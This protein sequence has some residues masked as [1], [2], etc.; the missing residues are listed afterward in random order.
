MDHYE[1]RQ[2]SRTRSSM[3]KSN[4]NSNCQMIP[5]THRNSSREG[6]LR[7]GVGAVSR[8]QREGSALALLAAEAQDQSTEY[9]TT[10]DGSHLQIHRQVRSHS[11]DPY[12]RYVRETR[13][14]LGPLMHGVSDFQAENYRTPEGTQV[15]R[16]F[17]SSTH[18]SSGSN[19]ASRAMLTGNT[20]PPVVHP[21]RD[22]HDPAIDF[23]D[24]GQ[25]LQDLTAHEQE[26]RAKAFA[27]AQEYLLH[28]D[29]IPYPKGFLPSPT[30]W[31]PYNLQR[32]H[33]DTVQVV[34][35]RD[36]SSAD[37][38]SRASMRSHSGGGGGEAHTHRPV[39]SG[40]ALQATPDR[41]RSHSALHANLKTQPTKFNQL[42][43][44]SFIQSESSYRQAL[45]KASFSGFESHMTRS[46]VEQAAA[47]AA[48]L[49]GRGA[50]VSTENIAP[51][52]T[53][54]IENVHVDKGG[55][56]YFRGTVNGS[57]PFDTIWYLND[58][59]LRSTN[60]NIE[61]SIRRDYTETY[62]TGLI[63]YIVSLKVHNCTQRDAGK[64][65]AY[66]RNEHGS[67]TSSAFLVVGGEITTHTTSTS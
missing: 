3:P 53:Y 7:R 41:L 13:E 28:T 4:S 44:S 16:S 21:R 38:I 10:E 65:T 36:T 5:V 61:T 29:G 50:P 42:Q 32:L 45:R 64:Y 48:D 40:S 31:R 51:N 57:Y 52:F 27:R 63:D 6:S 12:G 35:N 47:G 23:N 14:K 20:R 58:Q 43:S 18:S 30:F 11:N 59:E 62:M 17:M 24:N 1:S 66:I 26:A 39:G 19:L 54:Q 34:F 46:A 15:R 25:D 37:R 9:I 33:K 60:P 2:G 22:A 8:Q 67:T 55:T 49:A 56:A